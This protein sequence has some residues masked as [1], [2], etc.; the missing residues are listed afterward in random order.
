M[1]T[2]NKNSFLQFDSVKKDLLL[3]WGRPGANLIS[4]CWEVQ[5][6]FQIVS[7]SSQ[8]RKI[9]TWGS[10]S[11]WMSGPQFWIHLDLHLLDSSIRKRHIRSL[12]FCPIFWVIRRNLQDCKWAVAASPVEDIIDIN[13]LVNSIQL[14]FILCDL[15]KNYCRTIKKKSSILYRTYFQFWLH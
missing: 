8:I 14:A 3:T 13:T 15:K 2:R 7:V 11:L 1:E 5:K 10:C 9:S 12:I 4:I 6:R